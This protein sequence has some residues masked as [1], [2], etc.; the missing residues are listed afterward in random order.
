ML[1]QT[2]SS[3][4][5]GP[6]SDC[7][8]TVSGYR[9]GPGKMPGA[10][11]QVG[12][13]GDADGKRPAR[14]RLKMADIARMAGVDV[15]T[16]SRALA[17]SPRV[18]A[19][20]KARIRKVVA[21][22]GYV[23]NHNARTLRAQRSGLILVML[24]NIAS[25]NFAEVVLGIE[26]VA[27]QS[28]LNV[29]IGNTQYDPQREQLLGRQLLTGAVDGLILITGRIP[30]V[31]TEVP[32]F[33]RRI[34]AVSRRVPDADIPSISI[35]N[36]AAGRMITEHMLGL[37]H[38]RIV[39]LAGP[40][41]SPVFQAR[42]D[43]FL[44]VM[45]EAGHAATA[46]VVVAPSYDLTG[47]KLAMQEALALPERPSAV[48]CASDDMAIGAIQ[49]ARAAGVRVPQ[50]MAFSGFDDVAVSEAYEPALTTIRIPRR[51]IGERGARMLVQN[52]DPRR[53]RPRSRTVEFEL[54]VRNSTLGTSAR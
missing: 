43:S 36:H 18:T 29:V 23:V 35:D 10:V 17:D 34:V 26:E 21:Q 42:R 19:E 28:G 31:V 47:G 5:F 3:D 48:V 52:L 32:D 11:G 14:A 40:L 12:A 22:T 27:Q 7:D 25:S 15:S 20:T 2:D 38:R 16:I 41:E 4:G 13:M 46:T 1:E 30:D 51:E 44:E 53:P 9:S 6:A 39:H 54:I 45:G 37:G 49:A 8:P 50:D 24:P 33:E